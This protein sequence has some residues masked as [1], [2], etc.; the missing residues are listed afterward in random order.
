MR[1]PREPRAATA[2]LRTWA[3]GGAHR[4]IG[5]H[6]HI[7]IERTNV[8]QARRVA[9]A[10]APS[11]ATICQ[12]ARVKVS[13]RSDPGATSMRPSGPRAQTTRDG[14]W[15]AAAASQ[16]CFAEPG[17]GLRAFLAMH[18]AA[19]QA[20]RVGDLRQGSIQQQRGYAGSLLRRFGKIS[21]AWRDGAIVQDQIGLQRDDL[22]GDI[23][24][25]R[26][27]WQ[28]GQLCR[29]CREEGT[30]VVRQRRRPA[31]HQIGGNGRQKDGRRR[32]GWEY[33]P[34]LLW[35]HDA[36]PGRIDHAPGPGGPRP[37]QQ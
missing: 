24:P 28:L 25:P 17:Q 14:C 20:E 2:T 5:K 16:Q 18:D 32:T 11:G 7:R 27:P 37:G 22:L 13:A 9:M 4:R 21:I 1:A 15:R 8:G 31:K 33:A 23:V 10:P 19:E 29:L 34:N 3:I 36:A 6:D 30:R 12:P 35:H 26:Q